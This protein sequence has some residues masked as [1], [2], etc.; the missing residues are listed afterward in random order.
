MM[1]RVLFFLFCFAAAATHAADATLTAT[2]DDN[3]DNASRSL[4]RIGALQFRGGAAA[5]QLREINED[6]VLFYGGAIAAEAW[7]R[8]D[9]LDLAT[10]GPRLALQRKFGLGAFAPVLRLEL[11]ADA[12]AVRESARSGPAGTA[13][14]RLV[15][16]FS[17]STHAGISAELSRLDARSAVFARTGETL[18]ASLDHDLDERWRVSLRLAWRDGDVVSYATPPRPDLK[19]VSRDLTA[20]DTFDRPFIVYRLKAH[21][22]DYSLALSPALDE[23]TALSLAFGLRETARPGERYVN[24]LVSLTLTRQF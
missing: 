20:S 16:R 2:W 9:G 6:W 3:A 15:Q 7:P 12:V 11:G 13:T 5:R 17:T 8:Y 1:R 22:L 19:A 18:A 10:L 21:T 24:H 23:R 14:L 4:D